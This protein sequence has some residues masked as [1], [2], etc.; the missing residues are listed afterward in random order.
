MFKKLFYLFGLAI[1][2]N[3]GESQYI[4]P[5][6][7]VD[8]SGHDCVLDG[9]YQWCEEMNSCVRSWEVSCP[10]L[11]MAITDPLP[12]T[13]VKDCSTCHPFP[14][15]RPYFPNM[16]NCRMVTDRDECGCP[17]SC[18][19][20]DC[21]NDNCNSD[22]DCHQDQFCRPMQMRYPM[23]NGRRVQSSLS[24]CVDKVGINETC[25]GY[26]LPEF[27]TRCMDNLECVNTMG[28][29]IADAPGQCKA[30]CLSDE[31]R[32]Q[33][34][35]CVSL[36]PTRIPNNCAT[37][38]DGCNTCQVRDGRAEICTMMY[39]FRQDTPY[40]MSY[41]INTNSLS[42]GDVCYRFCEDGSQ[43]VINRRSDCP[44]NTICKSL[45]NEQSTSMISFD[46]CGDR[47]WTCETVGH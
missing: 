12:P 20:Y 39:C 34:G 2:A 6:S 30:P 23:S 35:E 1:S 46:S 28:P 27:Q 7:Q 22:L 45:F 36:T 24:E 44:S 11:A 15:A 10:S 9:G 21:T 13:P 14:C 26:T 17:T 3:F 16:N 47:S 31:S 32:N 40:C 42:V 19:H 29:M 37:W 4:M 5:G 43:D 41:H 18:P 38:H 33:Y 25:G 8:P